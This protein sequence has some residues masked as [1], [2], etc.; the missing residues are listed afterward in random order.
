MSDNLGSLHTSN[1]S[2]TLATWGSSVTRLYDLLKEAPQTENPYG[3]EVRSALAY[4]ERHQ[5]RAITGGGKS[6]GRTNS[7]K[8]RFTPVY[9][10]AG[11]EDR[12]AAL[13]V[14]EN[15]EL[16][17]RI[18]FSKRDVLGDTLDRPM[19]DLVLHHL[20]ERVRDVYPTVIRE[21]RPDGLVWIIPRDHYEDRPMRRYH[22]KHSALVPSQVDLEEVYDAAPNPFG[23]RYLA[24]TSIEGKLINV[25][26]YYCDDNAYDCRPIDLPDGA[27]GIRKQ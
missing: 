5:F 13:F 25:M 27:P 21:I 24:N 12:A 3:E 18:D 20:G 1:I 8:E 22:R 26:H 19:Y 9:Y 2:N 7:P 14:E 10:L 11:D 6:T 15:R 23:L 4:D 16:L 17:E